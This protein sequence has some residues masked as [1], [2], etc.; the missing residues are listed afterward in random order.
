M[1]CSNIILSHPGFI[2]HA[3]HLAKFWYVVGSL[4]TGIKLNL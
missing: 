2:C 1:D 4:R 3:Q